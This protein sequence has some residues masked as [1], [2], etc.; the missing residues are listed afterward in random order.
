MTAK[1]QRP[2]ARGALYVAEEKSR[3]PR[4]AVRTPSTSVRA[5]CGT[6]GVGQ[7]SRGGGHCFQTR[8]V[9]VHPQN[10]FIQVK[11]IT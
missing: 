6:A 4:G 3:F 8:S 9:R 10:M 5:P 1:L 7:G 2:R 11:S